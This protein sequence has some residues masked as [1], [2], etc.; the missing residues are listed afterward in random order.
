VFTT[1][2]ITSGVIF[3]TLLFL[4]HLFFFIL[5]SFFFLQQVFTTLFITSGVIYSVEAQENSNINNYF[6]AFYFSVTTLTTVGFGDIVSTKLNP[7]S[8]S[9]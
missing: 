9:S 8:K 2:F 3:T 4:P 6:D 1:R 5:N 7:R